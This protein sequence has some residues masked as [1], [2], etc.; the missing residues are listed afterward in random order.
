MTDI[1]VR[2]VEEAKLCVMVG[3][4]LWQMK[5]EAP[6]RYRWNYICTRLWWNH[7]LMAMMSH[8][9][10]LYH[11]MDLLMILP[12]KAHQTIIPRSFWSKQIFIELN[13]SIPDETKNLA[14]YVLLSL[15]HSLSSS[16]ACSRIS[17]M[18]TFVNICLDGRKKR[19]WRW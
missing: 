12:F 2:A 10:N 11:S 15:S 17:M 1:D 8:Y 3:I 14:N 19:R 5:H 18:T 16:F 6:A 4:L 7:D 13:C 9:K